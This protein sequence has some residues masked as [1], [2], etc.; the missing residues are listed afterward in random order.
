VLTLFLC[1]PPNTP[2]SLDFHLISG[3]WVIL[4][5]WIFCVSHWLS[6]NYPRCY[7]HENMHSSIIRV[8]RS[9]NKWTE[10][11]TLRKIIVI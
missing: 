9:N 10:P 11:Q 1:H 7:V 5:D 4:Q 3:R 8:R 2:L 6:Q